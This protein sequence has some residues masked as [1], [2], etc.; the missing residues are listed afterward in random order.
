MPISNNIH[1]M[2]IKSKKSFFLKKNKN[3]AENNNNKPWKT[4]PNIRPNIKGKK[5]IAKREGFISLYFG[6]LKT[7]SIYKNGK[8]RE[9]KWKWV[10]GVIGGSSMCSKCTGKSNVSYNLSKNERIFLVFEEG[11]QKNP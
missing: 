11:A 8:V 10:G 4:S 5:T 2:F 3:I 9:L 7:R 6:T 1:L